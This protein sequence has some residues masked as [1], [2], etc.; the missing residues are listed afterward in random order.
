MTHAEACRLRYRN[1]VEAGVCS[2]CGSEPLTTQSMCVACAAAHRGRM[3]AKTRAKAQAT[4]PRRL[5][6]C[7]ACGTPGHQARTC[8]QREAV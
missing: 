4:E 7:G 8:L 1:L 6:R 5:Y 2:Q 3:L